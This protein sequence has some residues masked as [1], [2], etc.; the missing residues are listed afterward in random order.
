[1]PEN[2]EQNINTDTVG[3]I[4]VSTSRQDQFGGSIDV[5]KERIEQYCALRGLNLTGFIHD[6][7]SAKSIQ[8]RPGMIQLVEQCR[9]GEIK[10]FVTCK[11]DRMFRNVIEGLTTADEFGKLGVDM[12]FMDMGDG[13]MAN[14]HTA[15]GRKFFTDALSMGEFERRRTGERVKEVSDSK[16]KAGKQHT[17]KAPYGWMFKDGHRIQHP[18]EVVTLKVIFSMHYIKQSSHTI[19]KN[20]SGTSH[21]TRHGKKVWVHSTIVG[22]LKNDVNKELFDLWTE[23]LN[24]GLI[25]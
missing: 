21:L 14:I 23:K 3:Y 5:Q 4:R 13:I 9:S 7:S 12:H 19:A 8:N 2:T 25:L 24:K 1:M 17:A 22:I 10:A 20:L 6:K 18:K 16:K 11:L 15:M